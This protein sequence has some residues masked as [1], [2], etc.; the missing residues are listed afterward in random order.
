MELIWAII[1]IFQFWP[2]N[3]NVRQVSLLLV[4]N[5]KC[6]KEKSKKRQYA[7][8]WVGDTYEE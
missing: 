8:M 6:R 2:E 1:L 4:E 3:G 5:D 7:N